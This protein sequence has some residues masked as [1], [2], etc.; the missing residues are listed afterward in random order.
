MILI[1]FLHDSLDLPFDKVMPAF[2]GVLLYP[3]SMRK[4][5]NQ[6]AHDEAYLCG[7]RYPAGLCSAI[8]ILQS[9]KENTS[10]LHER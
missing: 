10:Y 2:K 6:G 4:Q 5:E 1:R 7:Y 8:N 3:A 9:L